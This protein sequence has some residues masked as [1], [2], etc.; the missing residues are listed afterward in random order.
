M[1]MQIKLYCLHQKANYY[2]ALAERHAK[3]KNKHKSLQCWAKWKN[4]NKRIERIL[5]GDKK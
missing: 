2:A 3:H 4:T 1:K 5:L